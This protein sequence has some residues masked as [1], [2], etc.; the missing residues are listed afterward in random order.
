MA[1]SKDTIN[2]GV[3]ATGRGKP[4][5]V[6]ETPYT[7]PLAH[8]IVVQN[9]ALAINPIDWI[10]L[11][12]LGVLSYNWIKYPF[13]F[14]YDNA[15][16]VIEVG[17]SITRF[18]PGDRVVGLAGGM[19]EKTNKSSHSSFQ[20]YTVMAE[21]MTSKIPDRMSSEEAVVLPLGL[22]TAACGLFQ[23]DQLALEHP[24][25]PAKKENGKVLLVWGGSTSVGLNAI[26]VR[27][28]R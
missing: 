22:S 3:F 2:T 8:E 13:I 24:A 1:D 17:S 27:S 5:I 26:Q 4:F 23:K 9:H 14:G 10:L 16:T 18:K 25:V 15:G 28:L 11:T 12:H 7:H 20:K 21:H 6:K 19:D